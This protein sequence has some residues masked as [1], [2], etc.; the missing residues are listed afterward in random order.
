MSPAVFSKCSG[1]QTDHSVASPTTCGLTVF[2]NSCV[3]MLSVQENVLDAWQ[4]FA[5]S[6]VEQGMSG[7]FVDVAVVV[8][9]VQMAL[10]LASGLRK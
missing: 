1:S 5:S 9:V 4:S 6:Y 2:V 3:K 10:F 7:V 8:V